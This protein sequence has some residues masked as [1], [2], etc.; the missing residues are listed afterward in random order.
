MGVNGAM[1]SMGGI[2]IQT[3]P[4]Q[5]PQTSR[6]SAASASGNESRRD[7]PNPPEPGK[8]FYESRL[9]LRIELRFALHPR[10]CI[11]SFPS[12]HVLF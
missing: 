1:S 10:F 11:S 8:K 12:S 2:F 5:R 4:R 9:V 3:E 6:F 7:S